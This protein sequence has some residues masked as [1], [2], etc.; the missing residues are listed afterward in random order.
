MGVICNQ[1]KTLPFLIYGSSFTSPSFL[2][3]RTRSSVNL[4]LSILHPH[5][6]SLF[7][8][9]FTSNNSFLCILFLL[10]IRCL[11]LLHFPCLQL[12][13]FHI[14]FT[15][16]ELTSASLSPGMIT[17]LVWSFSVEFLRIIL[18]QSFSCCMEVICLHILFPV[19]L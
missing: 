14:F 11:C 13:F 7:P 3:R 1:S 10:T 6:P 19:R 9:N 17:D 2:E 18:Y 5:L 12:T 15:W 8:L 4:P 16:L